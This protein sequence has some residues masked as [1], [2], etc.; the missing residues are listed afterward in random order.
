MKLTP[1]IPKTGTKACAYGHEQKSPIKG[2][3][4]ASVETP[5]KMITSTFY[6]INGNLLRFT[7]DIGHIHSVGISPRIKLSYSKKWN[8]RQNSG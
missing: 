6:I 4:T 7:S 3:F 1:K 2:K 8:Q 5:K